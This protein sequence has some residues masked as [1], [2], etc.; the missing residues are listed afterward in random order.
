MS[1]ESGSIA[2][3]MFYVG[4]GLPKD[5]VEKFAKHEAPPLKSIGTG[6]AQGWVGG[7][8]LIDVPITEENAYYG[9]YLRV[10]LVKAE[11]K[12]PG[13]L[14]RAECMLEEVAYMRAEG[15]AYVDRKARS[16]IR[17]EVMG[18]LLP[19]MPP[20]LKGIPLVY[21]DR[22]QVM[23]AGAL[24]E[25]Q[26]DAFLISFKGTVGV[27]LIPV[28]A[29][30]A[31]AKR[32]GINVADWRKTSFSAEVGDEEMEEAPGLDFLTWLWFA[33]EARGGIF[34]TKEY[35][36]LGV[37]IEG[38]L[39]FTRAGAGAH[40]IS[41]RKGLP[42]VSAEAKTALL[43][44]KKLRRAK[45]MLARGDEKWTCSFD[46]EMFVFRGVRLPEPKEMLDPASRFQ[47]RVMRL[48]DFRV[49]VFWLVG[50]FLGG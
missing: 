13:S 38:P 31:A 30:T 32:R 21:D 16:D 37:A 2:V 18:R 4:K 7:R 34:A 11:R 17:K 46:A 36:E 47:E 27:N 33:S 45:V 9:G 48:G 22:E 10:A 14:L 49:L 19:T 15:K 29:G 12:V 6:A 44:G 8:H 20:T 26:L 40:E 25:S 41:L 28:N 39:L 50:W 35:G 1:F 42:T 23:Y 43:S 3:R 5:V 24:S